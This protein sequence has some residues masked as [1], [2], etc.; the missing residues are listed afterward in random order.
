MILYGLLRF[1]Q[2]SA[3]INIKE[4]ME[5]PLRKP[6]KKLV[7]PVLTLESSRTLNGW[8]CGLERKH[9]LVS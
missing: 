3:K 2:N 9:G 8:F 4:K 7:Y 1:F 6:A 5:K